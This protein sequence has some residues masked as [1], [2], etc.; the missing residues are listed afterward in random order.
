M[1]KRLQKILFV[2]ILAIFSLLETTESLLVKQAIEGF[3][4]G[5]LVGRQYYERSHPNVPY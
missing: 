3:L 5:L 4:I 1:V 2:W